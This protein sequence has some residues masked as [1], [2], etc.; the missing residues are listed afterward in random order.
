[1]AGLDSILNQ[2]YS[3]RVVNKEGT[4]SGFFREYNDEISGFY[5]VLEAITPSEDSVEVIIKNEENG[6]TE[7]TEMWGERVPEEVYERVKEDKQNGLLDEENLNFGRKA[8]GYLSISVTMK[9]NDRTPLKR[10]GQVTE[11]D[12]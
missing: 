12:N 3:V 8:I 11:W 7:K 1:M 4:R 5:L 6:Q 2:E 10:V 9:G